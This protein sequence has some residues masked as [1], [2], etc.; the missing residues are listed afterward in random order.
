MLVTCSA[1]SAKFQLPDEKIAGRKARM[2]C[3]NCGEPIVIDGTALRPGAPAKAPPA[4]SKRAAPAAKPEVPDFGDQTIA[5][6]QEDAEA[7]SRQARELDA[8]SAADLDDRITPVSSPLASEHQLDQSYVDAAMDALE[9]KVFSLPAPGPTA[10]PSGARA[11]APSASAG[12]AVLPKPKAPPPADDD[13][14]TQ[15]MDLPRLLSGAPAGTAAS[16]PNLE[17]EAEEATRMVDP[18]GPGAG[19]GGRRPE[20]DGDE[21][22]RIFDADPAPRAPRLPPRPS[23]PRPPAAGSPAAPAPGPEAGPELPVILSDPT[24]FDLP[25]VGPPAAD[26]VSVERSAPG[27]TASPQERAPSD[28]T[29]QRPRLSSVPQGKARASWG[30]YLFLLALAA[31]GS[32]IVVYVLARPTFDQAIV[33]T[34]QALGLAPSKAA[35]PA[36][37]AAAAANEL[38]RVA[39]LA[40]GCKKPNGPTGAGR[41][42]VLFQMSGDASSAAVSPPFHASSSEACLLGLF[43][44]AKVPKFG[45]QAVIVTKTFRV[46]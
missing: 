23:L 20:G 40:P 44:S 29:M 28:L 3:K 2:K 17:I 35:G 21:A 37:D 33:S 25:S 18:P 46:D 12:A 41:A 34:R 11:S 39:A 30:L 6:R 32:L 7:L 4:P 9:Q 45:G 15:M 43:K 5:L 10:G 13:E 22:T 24:P 38:A 26:G 16:R 42:R 19:L 31:T 1:C 36:F 14:A 8:P 27:A